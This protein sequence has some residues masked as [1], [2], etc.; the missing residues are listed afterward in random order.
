MNLDE[1][2]SLM[3]HKGYCLWI[4]AGVTI[5]LTS[6]STEPT[7]TW[8][9]FVERLEN[10]SKLKV[11]DF[12]CSLPKRL[13]VVQSKL[14]REMFQKA[15]RTT[16]ILS[17]VNSVIS[18]AKQYS[19]P[20]TIPPAVQQIACLGTLAN[21]IVSFNIE[22]ITSFLLAKP[23]GPYLI[24]VFLPPVPGAS[25]IHV[26]K[27]GGVRGRY[28]RSVYHPHGCIDIA[29]LCVLTESDY[30]AMK[31]TLAFELACHAAFQEI[32]VVVGMSLEDKYL[33]D[34]IEKF[35]ACIPKIIWFICGD[36]SSEIQKW[37]GEN[38]VELIKVSSWP[39]FWQAVQK[40]MPNPDTETLLYTWGSVITNYFFLKKEKSDLFCFMD[41]QRSLSRDFRLMNE[42]MGFEDISDFT[43]SQ[44]ELDE[45]QLYL[46]KAFLKAINE[47]SKNELE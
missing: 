18:I 7:W 38:D 30:N 8:E 10:I 23:G 29:G 45:D 37:V 27:E 44:I 41:N 25:A 15:V 32:L 2:L 11:S 26:R 39:H 43:L 5:H 14:G 31:G 42:N 35:R 19:S 20:F 4:G 47:L 9:Q 36:Q 13:E 33:R 1:A 28:K 34:Q 12:K 46:T 3:C 16:L 40:Q 24:K 6:E 17:L 21:S 22:S